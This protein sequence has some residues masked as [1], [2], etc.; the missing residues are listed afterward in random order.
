MLKLAVGEETAELKH[1]VVFEVQK[2]SDVNTEI[3][4]LVNENRFSTICEVG[5][6]GWEALLEC[7]KAFWHIDHE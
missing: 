3:E 7:T 1:W 6:G 2:W 5:N 4:E